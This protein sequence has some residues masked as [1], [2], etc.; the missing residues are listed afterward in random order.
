VI[1]LLDARDPGT[2]L[3]WLGGERGRPIADRV[4][5]VTYQELLR[6]SWLPAE[7]CIFGD[8]ETLS[9]SL[10]QVAASAWDA[11]GVAGVRRLNDPRRVPG[12][13]ELLRRLHALGRNDFRAYR[14]EEL[15]APLRYPVFVRREREHDGAITG[16]LAD[17][18][19]LGQALRDLKWPRTRHRSGDLLVVEYCDSSTTEGLHLRLSALRIGEATVPRYYTFS[20]DWV[21]KTDRRRVDEAIAALEYG[22]V[23]TNPDRAWIHETFD[24][25]EID[26]GRLDYGIASGRRQAWEIN[27]NPSLG[28]R[29][30][31]SPRSMELTPQ[32]RA[33]LEPGI[34]HAHAAVR[35]ALVELDATS[36]P[37]QRFT[38]RIPP[39]VRWRHQAEQ[40]LRLADKARRAAGAA[41]VGAAL[42]RF[43]SRVATL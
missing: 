7:T 14:L 2:V 6:A 30:R 12:R 33:L 15:P 22:Y 17:E 20:S 24:V 39:A 21:V 32:Q 4:R 19:E 3:D 36:R 28:R 10:R 34:R 31:P 41:T 25:A 23:T 13:Y 9:P 5:V 29:V 37:G 18:S 42:R 1:F 16:L 8:L 11:A 27:T 40:L 38:L 35:S 43:E 26:Y